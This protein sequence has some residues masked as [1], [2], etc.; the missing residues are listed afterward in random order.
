MRTIYEKKKRKEEV[1]YESIEKRPREE[2]LR[3]CKWRSNW[4]RVKLDDF[5]RFLWFIPRKAR[6][7]SYR[8]VIFVLHSYGHNWCFSGWE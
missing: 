5:T 4:Q 3:S 2:N 1:E 8:Q 7:V 6:D